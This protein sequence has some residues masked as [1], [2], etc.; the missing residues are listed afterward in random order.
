MNLYIVE[1]SNYLCERLT[2]LVA[3][4]RNVQVVG[5]AGTAQTAVRDI[6]RLHPDVVLLDIRLDQSSGLDVLKEIKTRSGQVPYVIV[7]TNYPYPQYR[8]R[9]L[10]DGADYFFDK[11]AE[12]DRMLQALDLLHYQVDRQPLPTGRGRVTLH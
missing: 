3:Q 4:R 10:A 7:L 12:L 5:H 6:K 2:R 1:N 11:S 8:E 9:F